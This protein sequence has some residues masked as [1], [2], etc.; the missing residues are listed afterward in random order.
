MAETLGY[1][2]EQPDRAAVDALSGGTVLVFGTNWCGYCQ[3]AHVLIEAALADHPDL[4]VIRAEDGPGRPLGR[5][6]GIK[7]WPTVVVLRDGVET[8]RVVRPTSADS[9]R[10][11]L[12]TAD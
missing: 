10:E 12:R 6:F 9:V 8:A 3:N 4:R 7:L 1:V 2:E 11:A 5:S